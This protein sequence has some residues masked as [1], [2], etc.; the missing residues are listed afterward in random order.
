MSNELFRAEVSIP[1]R[2]LRLEFDR[3]PV[4]RA[5]TKEA[6]AVRTTARRLIARKAI[7]DVGE[8]PGRE[9]GALWRSIK[10]KANRRYLYAAILPLRTPE[11][12]T[13]HPYMLLRGTKRGLRKLGEGEGRGVSNRRRRGDRQGALAERRDS[14]QFLVEPR[15]NYMQEALSRRRNAAR[16]A[17]SAALEQALR[18]G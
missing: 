16:D 9:T 5:I 6:R 10:V 14:S 3:R 15:G 7:S 17:I 13:F 8:F 12:G 1:S 11:M 2:A 18:M 4:F